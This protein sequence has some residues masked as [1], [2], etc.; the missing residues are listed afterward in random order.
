MKCYDKWKDIL[1]SL[2]F[3]YPDVYD[4]IVEWYPSGYLEITMILENGV[5]MTYCLVNDLLLTVFDPKE[6][7]RKWS[8][9][10]WRM[11]FARKLN[12]RMLRYGVSQ[13]ELSMK[14]GISKTMLSRY[15]NGK[16]L[17]SG[18]NITRIAEVLHCSVNELMCMR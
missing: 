7:D 15:M 8:D 10:D 2:E 5:K 11:N 13:E 18:A 12:K 16:A 14:T 9:D 1:D 17:P 3:T 6:K 4:Q